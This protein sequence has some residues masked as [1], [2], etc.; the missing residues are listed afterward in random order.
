MANCS[1]VCPYDLSHPIESQRS[2]GACLYHLRWIR[3]V[4]ES[5]SAHKSYSLIHAFISSW[6]SC[7][8]S[9]MHGVGTVHIW[10]TQNVLNAA[11][12][13]AAA[14][15]RCSE[16]IQVLSHHCRYPVSIAVAACSTADRIQDLC[17]F[18][19]KCLHEVAPAYLA[20]MNNPVSTTA[21]RHYQRSW[22]HDDRRH[23]GTLL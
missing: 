16:Y 7:C 23:S 9:I 15:Q 17:V 2:S 11:A 6:V 4:C 10:P 5:L 3:R 13:A 22:A 20:E 21:E 8:N 14:A 12:A 1:S 19:G 18:V